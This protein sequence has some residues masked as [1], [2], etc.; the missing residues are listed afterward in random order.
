MIRSKF[1]FNNPSL[2]S[3]NLDPTS[4]INQIRVKVKNGQYFWL[5]PPFKISSIKDI[6]SFGFVEVNNGVL[7]F[8]RILNGKHQSKNN[9]N[10]R[11]LKKEYLSALLYKLDDGREEIKTFFDFPGEIFQLTIREEIYFYIK[12][13]EGISPSFL[14]NLYLALMYFLYDDKEKSV[15]SIRRCI[16]TIKKHRLYNYISYFTK[17]EKLFELIPST[18]YPTIN[19]CYLI[20]QPNEF[21]ELP[22]EGL[23]KL[24]IERTEFLLNNKLK[25]KFI[26]EIGNKKHHSIKIPECS[27]K[28]IIFSGHAKPNN[29]YYIQSFVG[30]NSNDFSDELL[31]AEELRNILKN[32]ETLADEILLFDFACNDDYY[33]KNNYYPINV[34]IFNNG[35]SDL[36]V[37]NYQSGYFYLFGFLK[38]FRKKEDISTSHEFGRLVLSMYSDEFVDTYRPTFLKAIQLD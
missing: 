1:I 33:V 3:Q 36:G 17:I 22:D 21:F 10:L 26:S 31:T 12:K 7:Q 25:D 29:G 5:N 20:R 32:Y 28:I 8:N 4:F 18:D 11:I 9:C 38:T 23:S 15:F 24:Y 14:S 2:V 34:T 13:L 30:S 37:F 19:L 6:I 27:P 16:H 35:I